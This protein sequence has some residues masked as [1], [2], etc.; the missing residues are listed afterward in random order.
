MKGGR[1]D[2]HRDVIPVL[3]HHHD[4]QEHAQSEEEESINIML[5]G[6]ADRNAEGEQKD[7]AASEEDGAED[8]VADGP[9]VLEGTEDED[10]LGD[11]V[12]GDADDGP[13]KVDHEER[14][15]LR[16]GESE[17]AFEG[18]DGDEHAEPK[19]EEA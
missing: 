10:E 19:D 8:D 5:N 11:D 4:A 14:H 13:Q 7:L 2:S 3:V 18:A 17:L 12:H 9:A 15:R 1:K 6:V 16:E